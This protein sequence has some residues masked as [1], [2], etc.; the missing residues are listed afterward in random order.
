MLVYWP[1]PKLLKAID[2]VEY[3]VMV[4]HPN[5]DKEG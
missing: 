1:I 3:V 5:L 2:G 4:T